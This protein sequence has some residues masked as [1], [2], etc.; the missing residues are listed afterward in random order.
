[1][2]ANTEGIAWGGMEVKGK[3]IIFA[4]RQGLRDCRDVL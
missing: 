4:Q 3:A 2:K 1:M